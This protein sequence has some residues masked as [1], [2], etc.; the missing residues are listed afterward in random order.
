MKKNIC[1]K[2]C[3]CGCRNFRA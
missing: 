2:I 1:S 3:D